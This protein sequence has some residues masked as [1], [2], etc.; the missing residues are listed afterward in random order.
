[1]V[2]TQQIIPV[3]YPLLHFR[4]LFGRKWG[5]TRRRPPLGGREGGHYGRPAR[6]IQA[7]FILLAGSP[8]LCIGTSQP[9]HSPQG[10]HVLSRGFSPG[11]PRNRLLTS[12]NTCSTISPMNTT[13]GFMLFPAPAC[14]PA[15][16]CSSFVPQKQFFSLPISGLEMG[17]AGVGHS[18]PFVSPH[19]IPAP[20]T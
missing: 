19:R 7:A 17:R 20:R 18:F 16:N 6:K 10:F 4:P 13:P 12:Q 3:G 11:V 1:M 8:L 5:E 14:H 2:S 9:P 15:L